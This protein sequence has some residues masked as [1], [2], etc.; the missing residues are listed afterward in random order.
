MGSP[1]VQFLKSDVVMTLYELMKPYQINSQIDQQAFLDLLQQIGESKDLM[2]LQHE[3]LDD[4]V[5]VQV[6]HSWIQSYINAYASLFQALHLGPVDD[7][8]V[9]QQNDKQ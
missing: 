8:D 1:G 4:W 7:V 2:S 6:V 9:Q 3:M 5:P